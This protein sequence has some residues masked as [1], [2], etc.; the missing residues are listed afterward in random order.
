[1]NRVTKV[2][3]CAALAGILIFS[4]GFFSGLTS[5][6]TASLNPDAVS[7]ATGSV[8]ESTAAPASTQAPTETQPQAT[9]ATQT[10]EAQPQGDVTETTQAPAENS[11]SL[12]TPAEIVAYFNKSA[13]KVKTDAVKVTRNWEDLHAD[14]EYLEVPSALQ[15]IGKTLMTT[16]LKKDETPLV[17]STK[18]DIIANFPVKGQTFVSNTTE[19]DIA[20]ATCED[21]GTY[22]N[23]KL[24]Y[25]ECTDPTG[26]GCDSAF[27]IMRADDVYEAASMVQKFS[28]KYYD[29]VIECKI[30]KAT[31][32]MVSA[33]YTLPMIMQVTAKVIVSIDAQVGMTFIDDYTIEY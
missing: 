14:N 24:K 4:V 19:A 33:T 12:S 29:A 32:N 25:K 26:T 28:V 1:M 6:I 27:N 5:N 30:D 18:D 13:N 7:D 2:A 10:T 22:Y 17:W 23:I 31:G 11:G 3:I 21:D 20:E 15:A 16:F 8:P 9:E